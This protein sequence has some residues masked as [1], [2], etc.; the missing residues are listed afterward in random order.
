MRNSIYYKQAELLL[1]ILPYIERETVFALKGGTAINFFYRNLPRL[2][3]DIDLTYLPI[4]DRDIAL[5]DITDRLFK[6]GNTARSIIPNVQFHPQR[7]DQSKHIKGLIVNQNG[8]TVKVTP[9]LVIRSTVYPT[10]KRHLSE[11]AQELFEIS[12]QANTVSFADLFGGKICAA[13]DRQHPRDLFDIK[14]LLQ[15]EGITE[16]IKNAFVVYLISHDR[17]M[18]EVLNP[19]LLDI[20]DIFT[21]EFK[22]IVLEEITL[23]ELIETRRNLIQLVKKSLTFEDR[24]FILSVK[25][26][27]PEWGLID[28]DHIKNLPA[29]KWKLLNLKK[30]NPHKHRKAFQKLAE[31]LEI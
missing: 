12:I 11:K 27:N 23:D 24:K 8:I 3:V 7:I 26:M 30:M 9:N 2:S 22:G 16:R 29:V 4:S 6:I 20:K 21:K 19:S 18:I 28:L 17:P 15:N 13:L 14:L 1:K 5:E 31:Y 10:E 25:N